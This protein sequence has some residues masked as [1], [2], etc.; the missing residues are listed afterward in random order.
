MFL[1]CDVDGVLIP[2]DREDGHA[3]PTH[4]RYEVVPEGASEPVDVWLNVD[5]GTL[6]ADLVA[7]TGLSPVWCTSWRGDAARLIGQALRLPVWPH[8]PLPLP[9]AETSHPGGYLWKRDLA[10]VYAAGR[11]LAWIDDQFATPAD[12]DWAAA[13]DAAGLPTLLVPTDPSLGLQPEH[14]DTVRRWALA[15]DP[16][17]RNQA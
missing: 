8:V 10:D 14:A 11:P 4:R 17:W 15:L 3:P 12:H 9:P 1:L 2:L 5:H 13:R 16:T 7:A 6:L